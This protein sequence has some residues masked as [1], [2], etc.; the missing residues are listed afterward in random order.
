[1]KEKV[2]I[3]EGF[4]QIP[5]LIIIIASI[6]VASGG[7]GVVLYRQGKLTSL[8]ANISQIFKSTE[9]PVTIESEKMRSETEQIS[10]S[11]EEAVTFEASKSSDEKTKQKTEQ[12]L[13]T[14]GRK[15]P[16]S[17]TVEDKAGR[18]KI[19]EYNIGE[20]F[21]FNHVV[22]TEFDWKKIRPKST[23]IIPWELKIIGIK[24]NKTIGKHAYE[25]SFPMSAKGKFI[26]VDIWG[27]NIG[28]IN[29]YLN[30]ADFKLEDS[31]GRKFDPFSHIWN[32]GCLVCGTN[33]GMEEREYLVYDIPKDTQG[34]I[35]LLISGGDSF[36]KVNLGEI[37]EVSK[38]KTHIQN[39]RE[40]NFGQEVEILSSWVKGIFLSVSRPTLFVS[41]DEF[42]QPQKGNKFITI[43]VS[44]RNDSEANIMNDPS[45]FVL[46]DQNGYK[47][48][49]TL[50]GGKEPR[51]SSGVL[52]SG[53]SVR[54]FITYEV[55]KNARG[56]YV[57]YSNP[58]GEIIVFK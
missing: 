2:K 11:L 43:E 39:P 5:L 28:N 22:V 33:P 16:E 56:F 31:E 51:F 41:S 6:I 47:Y 35:A 54:G 55:P 38:E 58:Q 17:I 15:I 29:D 24:T 45:L 57:V 10:E 25:S 46:K 48:E 8:I 1:M 42:N 26:L 50:W 40:V 12:K 52:P 13:K 9:K 23:K 27:K 49:R 32:P 21:I 4:I 30:L 18:K 37:P 14:K 44:Y 20:K 36:I 53:D 34:K 7:A 19:K 3:Q